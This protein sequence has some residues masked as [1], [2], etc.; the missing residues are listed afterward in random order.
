MQKLLEIKTKKSRCCGYCRWQ[1]QIFPIV[2][3]IHLIKFDLLKNFN[4]KDLK[5]KLTLN[6]F[7]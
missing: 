6:W 3:L 5:F 1:I 7:P 2:K 4:V